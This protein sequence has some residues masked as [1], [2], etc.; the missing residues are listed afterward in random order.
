MLENYIEIKKKKFKGAGGRKKG[1]RTYIPKHMVAQMYILAADQRLTEFQILLLCT[2]DCT[3]L[4]DPAAALTAETPSRTQV[5]HLNCWGTWT[6]PKQSRSPLWVELIRGDLL[7]LLLYNPSTLSDWKY[8]TSCLVQIQH[9]SNQDQRQNPEEYSSES[10][11]SSS[12]KP[13]N[14]NNTIYCFITCIWRYKYLSLP[15][16]FLV[17]LPLFTLQPP[18]LQSM[19]SRHKEKGCMTCPSQWETRSGKTRIPIH[20]HFLL[21]LAGHHTDEYNYFFFL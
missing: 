11:F 10:S 18:T 14:S 1:K 15:I 7:V 21:L 19:H 16:S 12:R 20:Q 4:C 5:R 2:R 9:Q 8:E 13:Q 3:F 17:K 6:L